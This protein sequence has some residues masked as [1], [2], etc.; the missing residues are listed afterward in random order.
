MS[1]YHSRLPLCSLPLTTLYNCNRNPSTCS[2]NDSQPHDQFPNRQPSQPLAQGCPPRRSYQ[3]DLRSRPQAPRGS[4][5][6]CRG[7]E[8]PWSRQRI[9]AQ[10]CSCQSYLAEAQY[11]SLA[12]CIL[13]LHCLA[14]AR[15]KSFLADLQV[16]KLMSLLGSRFVVTDERP[17]NGP[18]RVRGKNGS[19]CAV[20][21]CICL[22]YR[23]HPIRC[24][25]N[26]DMTLLC[27][28][29]VDSVASL[30]SVILCQHGQRRRQV[31]FC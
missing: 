18:H 13:S 21:V 2:M 3:L 19:G 7:E 1:L 12:I 5:S 23:L 6:H 9:E 14:N 22:R 26:A 28:D 31:D 8:E 4:R 16:A 24:I 10:P 17:R 30:C 29:T 15:T 11:V 25:E 20:F 27:N